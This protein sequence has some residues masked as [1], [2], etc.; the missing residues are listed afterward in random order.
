LT[1]RGW[2]RL[3]GTILIAALGGGLATLAGLPASWLSG[4]M[5]AVTA[6]SLA[7]LNTRPPVRLIEGVFLLIGAALGSGV[8][9]ELIRGAVA[10]PVSLAGLAVTVAACIVGVRAFL[11]RVA[12]WD[13]Q[14][15]FFSAVPGALSYVLALASE[16]DADIRKVA[17][18][19]SIRLFLLV[20]ALPAVILA[21][22]GEPAVA[23]RMA[24]SSPWEILAVLAAAA[25]VGLLFRQMRVPGG[26]L[27]G[28]LVGSG[29]L[30]GTGLVS[31]SL[32]MPMVNCAFILL[33]TLIG[34]RFAGTDLRFLGRIL[35]ASAGAFVVATGIALAMAIGVARLTGAPTD[36]VIVAFAPGGLD[37][38]M[39]LSLALNMDS[40]FVAAHQFAR[41]AGIAV[42]LPFIARTSKAPGEEVV[43]DDEG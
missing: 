8:T 10:W 22:E 42:A 4:S 32:P 9:P 27:T 35:L 7:G 25:S 13:R 36:Q 41:F 1:G 26:L 33:G 5:I 31:G 39:S 37:A 2:L 3:A 17:T 29:I 40:A 6:A 12:G 34:S 14:T 19:Q 30:H 11:V 24:A 20:A 16:T 43:A 38:M 21:I 23:T 28:A 18:S 15:A